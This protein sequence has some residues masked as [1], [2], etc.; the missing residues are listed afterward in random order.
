M[1][2][3]SIPFAAVDRIE[4]LK[5]GASALYGSDA[6]AGVV[7]VILKNEYQGA[8]IS[9]YYGVS[10]RGDDEVWHVQL[11]PGVTHSFNE[12]ASFRS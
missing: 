9:T 1:D 12:N 10:Q 5:D 7:N 3:N 6:I 4:V 2:L 11:T 8:G